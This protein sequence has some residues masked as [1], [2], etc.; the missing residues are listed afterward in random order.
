MLKCHKKI[1]REKAKRVFELFQDGYYLV[2]SGYRINNNHLES[3]EKPLKLKF[4]YFSKHR[5]NVGYR[6]LTSLQEINLY[7]KKA[8]KG[9]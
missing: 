1:C 7:N 9:C 5:V 6:V 8:K 2:P 4:T 3:H